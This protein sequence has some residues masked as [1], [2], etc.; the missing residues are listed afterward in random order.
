MRWTRRRRHSFELKVAAV[1]RPP[2]PLRCPE[3]DSSET[4][5]SNRPVILLDFDDVIVLNRPG[6]FGGFDVI[7]ANPPPELW[8]RLFHAPATQVLVEALIE[9]GAQVVITTSWLRFML[10]DAFEGLFKKTGL[11]VLNENLHDAWE[12]PQHRG[13]TRVQAIDRW[14]AA[15]HRGEP[16]VILDDELSG[17]GLR[18]SVH[19]RRGRVV[20][21]KENVGLHRGHM[22]RIRT[23]LTRPSD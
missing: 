20:L 5:V 16:Y 14:L 2:V 4:A 22:A 13:E 19:D 7:S 11:D 9:H 3:F 18:R 1:Q 10:R 23:A 15:H 12:A 21:C 8:S 17:T 6:E